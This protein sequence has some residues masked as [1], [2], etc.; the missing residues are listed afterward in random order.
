MGERPSDGDIACVVDA[1]GLFCPMP[2]A[3]LSAALKELSPG[4]I[5]ELIST[6]PGTPSDLTAFCKAARHTLIATRVE[7]ERFTAWVQKKERTT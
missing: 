6:D 5:V 2:I 1:S 7:P 3:R 4:A